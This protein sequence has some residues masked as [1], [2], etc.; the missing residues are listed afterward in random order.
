MQSGK[1]PLDELEKILSIISSKDPRVVLGPQA[2]E[3]AALIDMGDRYLVATTDPITFASD[4]IGWYAV[5]INANDIVVMGGEPRW[6]LSNLL[7]PGGTSIKAVE[8]IFKQL[9]MACD[10]LNIAIIGGHTEFVADLA[11]P[12]ITGI[13]LGEV[14]K[15][16]EVRT[17]AAQIDDSILLTKSIPIEG[18]A[19]LA[20]EATDDLLA[21]GVNKEILQAGKML[22]KDPGI[23]VV[24][25]ARI[26]MSTGK[27]NAMHD[28]TEGGLSG[29]LAELAR[30][31]QLGLEIVL[32]EI[33]IIPCAKVICETLK[34]DPLGIIASGSLLITVTPTYEN[35]VI[36]TLS[37]QGV[38]VSKIG[39]MKQKD[40][41]L[42]MKTG[43]D[44]VDLPLFAQDEITRYL[45]Q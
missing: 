15:G 11:R 9:K 23:S 13:M 33:P 5:H 2:G 17:S 3:D 45:G 20:R 27:I 31:S 37:S 29:G 8:D 42:K 18:C 6:M 36:N 24:P 1:L 43:M 12:I 30:A 26:A 10:E 44:R 22:L 40:Y 41:G 25:E 34:L 16:N 14:P 4:Q 7:I 32:D 21:S 19:I 28:P 35:V 38:K 39:V